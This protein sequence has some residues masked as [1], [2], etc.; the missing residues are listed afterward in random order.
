[1]TQIGIGISIANQ[2]PS[3]V[4]YDPDASLFIA[5]NLAAGGT[6][7]PANKLAIS[8]LFKNFKGV[9]AANSTSNIYSRIYPYLFAGG[10]ANSAKIQARTLETGVF[11]GSSTFTGNAFNTSANSYFGLVEFYDVLSAT[12]FGVLIN[13]KQSW[14]SGGAYYRDLVAASSSQG[15]IQTYGIFIRPHFSAYGDH[16]STSVSSGIFAANV[17]PTHNTNFNQD[18]SVDIINNP[19]YIPVTLPHDKVYLGTTWDNI[20]IVQNWQSLILTTG[21]SDAEM[22]LLWASVQQYNIEI[23]L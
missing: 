21:L 2:Q 18:G 4:S 12:N 10:T 23:A 8:N 6:L 3:G 13:G 11:G 16:I 7:T 1:M 9:G 15:L 22:G 17:T 19:P 20:T 14:G 5:A